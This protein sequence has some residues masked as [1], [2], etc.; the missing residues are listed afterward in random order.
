MRTSS[1]EG[2]PALSRRLEAGDPLPACTITGLAA[3]PTGA[4]AAG[5]GR[6]CH[7]QGNVLFSQELANTHY[8]HFRTPRNAHSAHLR[9]RGLA[10]LRC[11]MPWMC[12]SKEC[13]ESA[14]MRSG[15]TASSLSSLVHSRGGEAGWT[16]L[17]PH[18]R[19]RSQD[20]KT[21]TSSQLNWHCK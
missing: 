19:E 1:A 10:E 16:V 5:S 3:T 18:N 15:D 21:E 4:Q 13:S 17:L 12:F 20:R 14:T 11:R 9:C 2:S 7:A 8:S 6:S